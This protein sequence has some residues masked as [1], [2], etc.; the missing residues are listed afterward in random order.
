MTKRD[1]QRDD[2]STLGVFLNGGEIPSRTVR[3]EPISDESFLLLFNAHYE[4][5]AFRL[6]TR[7]FGSR[8]IVDLSTDADLGEGRG[9]A[10]RAQLE[11]TDR[12]MVLL[13]RL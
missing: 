11:L 2:A 5:V 9:F 13:R 10:A 4:R 6:P 1:W 3:G 12:A 8:W 7:R